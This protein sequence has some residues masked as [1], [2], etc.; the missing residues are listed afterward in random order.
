MHSTRTLFE[1]GHIQVLEGIDDAGEVQRHLLLGPPFKN[2]QGII[3]PD[4]PKFHVQPFTRNLTFGALLIP[5]EVK[6]VLFLGLGAG[7]VVQAIRDLFPA[8]TIDIVDLDAELFSVSNEFFFSIDA[9]NVHWFAE[10][11][12]GFVT[13]A[14]KRYDYICCDIWGDHLQVPEFLTEY[15]FIQTVKRIL[16]DNGVFA[17]STNKLL[18]AH[19]SGMMVHEF[20]NVFSVLAPTCL[21]IGLNASPRLVSDPKVTA[22]LLSNN[23]DINA[24]RDNSMLIRLTRADDLRGHAD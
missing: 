4:N 11:A 7:V 19:M 13:K 8:A 12:A 1:S 9:E 5:G 23:V 17:I 15:S 21:L 16:S 2:P 6:N 22:H 14:D 18:H 20:R 24:I 3:K 10:D